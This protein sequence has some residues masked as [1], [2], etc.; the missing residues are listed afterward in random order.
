MSTVLTCDCG[1]RF[2]VDVY[3]TGQPIRCPEC[4]QSLQVVAH[5]KPPRRPSWL[6][7][8]SLGLVLLGAFTVIGSLAGTA[9]GVASLVHLRRHRDRLAGAGFAVTAIVLGFAMTAL[10]LTLFRSP[11]VPPVAAWLRARTLT[12]QVDPADSSLVS[13]RDEVCRLAVPRDTWLRVKATATVDPALEDLQKNRDVVLMHGK[14]RAYA[15]VTLDAEAAGMPDLVGS[16]A[17]IVKDLHRTRPALIGDDEAAIPARPR[18]VR[19][20][21]LDPID[22][23][24]GREWLLDL[25]R[26]GQ[27]WRILVRA[28]RLKCE[29]E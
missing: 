23:H 16:H 8:G 18:F 4:S 26:G 1:A 25:A 3:R 5:G 29:K 11:D 10:T 20:A 21:H 13:S 9:L 6:A 12:G 2:E 14:A 27:T 17:A 24:E 15:D 19:D 28:Y 22:G 7:L